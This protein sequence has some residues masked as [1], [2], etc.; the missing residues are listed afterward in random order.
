MLSAGEG[1]MFTGIVE[2][3]GE[4]RRTARDGPLTRLVVACEGF[5]ADIRP[6]DSIS[7]NGVCLTVTTASPR[8][9][10]FDVVEETVSRTT[11][12]RLSPGTRVNLEKAI[13]AGDRFGGHFVSGHI[14]G[15]GDLLRRNSRNEF[16][17]G[18]SQDLALSMIPKGSVA[19]DGVSLTIASV[20][21]EGFSVALVP[22][23]LSHTTL[24]DLAPGDP[25]N[26]ETDLIGKWVRRILEEGAESGTGT[27]LDKLR[28]HGFA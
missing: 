23:T 7:V 11:L 17:F 19:V 2:R 8:E 25:V 26:I 21:G 5:T 12:A 28:E 24:G 4:V 22:W 6:E 15:A 10:T 1:G 27:T 13:K 20:D 9:I 16:T 18:V 14:D 3:I